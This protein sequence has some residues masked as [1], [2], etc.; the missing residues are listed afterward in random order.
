V[1]DQQ[2]CQTCHPPASLPHFYLLGAPRQG[3][4]QCEVCHPSGSFQERATQ[5]LVSG[6]FTGSDDATCRACHARTTCES[7]HQPPHPAGW[8]DDHGLAAGE[9]DTTCYQCHTTTWCADRCHAVTQT[10]P[11]VPRPLPTSG[12]HP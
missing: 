6:D 5:P 12:V 7:C 9:G 2:Q 8:L 4:V 3:V 1:E 11:L 10:N